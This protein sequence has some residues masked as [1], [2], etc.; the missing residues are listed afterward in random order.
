MH[1]GDQQPRVTDRLAAFSA[2]LSYDDLPDEVRARARLFVLDGIGVMLGAVAFAEQEGDHTLEAYLDAVAPDG[3]ATVVGTPRMT[4]PMMAGFANGTRSEVLDSQDTN[5]ECRIHNG[6]AIIP[7]A[8]A[9][10]EVSG[11]SGRDLLAA[12]VAG[13]EVGCRLAKATQPAHWYAGFQITG[14]FNTCGAAATAGRLLG[15]GAEEMAAALGISGFILPISNGDNV[16]KG[17]SIKPVHGGQPA[18]CGISSAYL[19]KAGYRSGPLE[20][21]PPRYHAAL[22]IL[23]SPEPALDEAVRG[24][25]ERWHSL[26]VGFKPY[27]VGL[28]IN[29]P[30]EVSLALL[31]EAPIRAEDIRDVLITT[32]HDGRKFTGEK[33]TTTASNYVDAHLSMPYCVAATLIDGAMSWR[34]LTM[35]RL[36]DPAV[37]ELASRI[38]VVESEEMNR[39]YPHEWPLELEVRLRDGSTRAKRIAQVKWSPRRP[40]TW[41]ELSAKFHAMADPVIGAER[42]RQAID[43]VADL[44]RAPSLTPLMRLIAR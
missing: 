31:E 19:A 42:A 5:I 28:F 1:E 25:G 23:G 32:Y 13:Y 15:F 26:E 10:A 37:H 44:E 35:A 30:V 11:A 3:P 12:V 21:E 4:S 24:I 2:A 17:H 38:K 16:F 29:G 39:M 20:G 8:L 33:Y 6:A 34:Q 27:P 7:A 43:F 40:P 22:H 41:P 18:L 36:A 9:M 14:T